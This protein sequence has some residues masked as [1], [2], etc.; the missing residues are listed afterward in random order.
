[1]QSSPPDANAYIS[2]TVHDRA[3]LTKFLTHRVSLHS[4]HPKFQ[5][6]FV[7]SKMATI[8][9]VKIFRKK[10]QNTKMLISHKPS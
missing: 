2:K 7:S 4:S 3:I 1:M 6:K 10:L 9:N 8:L 5:K